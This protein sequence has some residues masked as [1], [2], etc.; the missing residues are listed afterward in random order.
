[1]RILASFAACNIVE[2]SGTETGMPFIFKFTI[3]YTALLYFF[4]IAPNL[5]CAMHWPHLMHFAVS[6]M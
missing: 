4:I 6:M 3:L 5:Q 2:P 1:M